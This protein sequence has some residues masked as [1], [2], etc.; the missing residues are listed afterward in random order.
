MNWNRV[1]INLP[2]IIGVAMTAVEAVKGKT[3][4]EKEAAVIATVKESLPV[5]EAVAG[6]DVVN[7]AAFD[8]LLANY[9]SARVAL[10]NFLVK[11]PPTEGVLLPKP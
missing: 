5:V 7:D 3:G 9:I 10:A 11:P 8:V 4:K 1:L 6:R 2:Q